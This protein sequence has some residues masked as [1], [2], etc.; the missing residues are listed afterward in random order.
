MSEK[1]KTTAEPVA[2]AKATAPASAEKPEAVAYC[3]PTIKGIAAQGTVFVNG[4]PD[5]LTEKITEFPALKGLIVPRA[6]FAEVRA[7]V[8]KEGTA[9][10]ILFKKAAVLLK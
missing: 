6:K 1:E 5:K 10:N 2:P 3:G 4:L 7:K 8:E 9:E